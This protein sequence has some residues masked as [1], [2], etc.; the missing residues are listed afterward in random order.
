MVL[1][2]FTS[3]PV[4]YRYYI[5]TT[6]G[7]TSEQLCC[8]IDKIIEQGLVRSAERKQLENKTIQNQPENESSSVESK[9]EDKKDKNTTPLIYPEAGLINRTLP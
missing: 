1:F 4:C 9:N 7:K 8:G 2:L 6:F 5:A 3:I